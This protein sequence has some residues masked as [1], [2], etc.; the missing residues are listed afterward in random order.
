MDRPYQ[1]AFYLGTNPPSMPGVKVVDVTPATSTPDATIDAF[2][3]ADI[4]AADTR[5]QAVLV[6]DTDNITSALLV[7]A[8]ALGFT[9][10]R[11][12]IALGE[13]VIDAT[14]LDRAAR[15]LPDASKPPELVLQAQVAPFSRDDLLTIGT[16]QNLAPA[17]VS[18]IRYARRLRWVPA[19]SPAAALA[20]LLTIAGIRAKGDNDRLPFLVQGD[21]PPPGD[22]PTVTVGI[23]LDE[24][25]RA[26]RDLR[27][28]GRVGD[29][30]ALAERCDPT[31]RQQ[32]L[33]DA[34]SAPI[35]DVLDRLGTR[36]DPHTHLWHCPRPQRHNNRDANASMKLADS[37]VRCLGCDD[38]RID[39]LRLV[40]DTL[41]LAV[42][43]AADWLLSDDRRE[44]LSFGSPPAPN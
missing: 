18:V 28:S 14:R 7:Y 2:T 19:G 9:G 42:D 12:D 39:V 4:T 36:P 25:R 22:D 40:I 27:R 10:R 20:Q 43:D 29:R 5:S 30:D 21:E 13:Q 6:I 34:A 41:D 33:Q 37:T 23:C 3:Q 8:A 16:G 31:P 32:R 1:L 26:A 35:E 15:K 17:E 38:E 24:L 11:I 44:P